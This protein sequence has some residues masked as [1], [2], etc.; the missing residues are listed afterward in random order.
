MALQHTLRVLT[1]TVNHT[2]MADPVEDSS[3]HG[4]G[5]VVHDTLLVTIEPKNPLQ[6]QCLLGADIGVGESTD[7]K[8]NQRT[9][10]V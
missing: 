5:D 6:C 2:N 10:V 9:L 8:V 4:V 1:N 7:D 3:T